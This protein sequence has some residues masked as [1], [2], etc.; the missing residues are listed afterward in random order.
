M[1]TRVP[2]DWVGPEETEL[3]DPLPP[4]ERTLDYKP[5]GADPR[6]Y[7]RGLDH[8]NYVPASDPWVD[9]QQIHHIAGPEA[10]SYTHLRAHETSAHL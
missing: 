4:A 9:R 2:V 10:V 1:R 8:R 7:P 5:L 3:F 6:D